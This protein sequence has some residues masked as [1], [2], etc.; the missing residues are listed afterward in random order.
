[1]E[2]KTWSARSPLA[3]ATS[4]QRR[5]PSSNKPK[6]SSP[7][8]SKPKANFSRPSRASGW[9]RAEYPMNTDRRV[10]L[11]GLGAITPIGND[12]DT[13]WRNCLNGVSGVE[14][15]QAFDTEGY[16]CRIAGEVRN[17]EPKDFFKNPKDPPRADRFLQ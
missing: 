12:I 15:I 11:T 6:S 2:V 7:L 9:E 4:A 1:M 16:D 17:F 10:V 5:S 14:R 13:L 3:W 8:R